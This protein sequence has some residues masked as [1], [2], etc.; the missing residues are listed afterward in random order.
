MNI[1]CGIDVG[2]TNT[3]I[4]IIDEKGN[5]LEK[6]KINT[7]DFDTAELFFEE[8]VKQILIFLNNHS[9]LI[10]CGIGIGAPNGNYY[11]GNIEF[12]PNLKW[13][14]LIR[15]TKIMKSLI[16]NTPII[17]TNDANAAA[18]GEK[19]YGSAK[20]KN[21]FIIITLGTGVGSGIVVNGKL[22]YGHD[23]YAGEIGH[24]IFD[25]NGRLCGCGRKGC[26]ETYASASGM[27]KTA[28]EF[29]ERNNQSS[30]LRQIQKDKLSAFDIG[31]A[32][33]NNDKIA[34]EIFDFTARILGI[35]LADAVAHT[36]PS[37]I[38]IF[39]GLSNA[40]DILME[41]LKKY[42]NEYLLNIYKDKVNLEFSGLK[43]NNAA[44]LGAAALVAHTLK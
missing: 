7:G 12:A 2:G 17:L 38:Y 10:L 22:V 9:D 4:G 5:I 18:L 44:I 42:F 35:K 39:G 15:V 26:L 30:V 21:D 24:S 32:A 19:Y 11:S 6:L 34:L 25:P 13:K 37:T 36:S 3:S 41:P 16:P 28:L 1:V 29:L 40:G 33:K 43:Q 23:G 20:N 27:V 8:I 14:G 31:E